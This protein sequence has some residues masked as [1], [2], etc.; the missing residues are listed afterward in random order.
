MQD[1]AYINI[2]AW[3]RTELDLKGNDLLVY[4]IIYGFSQDGDSKFSGSLQY[5]ADWCGCTK[6][7]ILKNIKH[8]IELNLI[9]KT[10]EE[11]NGIKRCEYQ[12][13]QVNGIKHSLMGIKHSLTNNKA[14]TKDTSTGIIRDNTRRSGRTLVKKKNLYESCAD[15]I[16]VCQFPIELDQLIR[17]YLSL[18]LKMTDKPIYARSQWQA[19]LKKLNILAPNDTAM[20]MAI[21]QQSIERGYASFFPVNS[22]KKNMK[23]KAHEEG[24]SCEHL[25]EEERRAAKKWRKEMEKKGERVKF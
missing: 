13:T 17:S 15:E 1:L 3:M 16:S 8:L 21:V 25:T 18:R 4:A 20:Q 19:I 24:V 12:T 9:Q 11:K 14:D 23:R 5:L 22:S 7:G 2:Q 6:Q 10:E